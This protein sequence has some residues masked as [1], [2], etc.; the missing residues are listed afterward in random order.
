MSSVFSRLINLAGNIT[1]ILPVANGGTGLASGTSGG[2]LA[3]TAA[4]TLASSGALT[5]S[6]LVVGGGAGA[7]PA[8]LALG[9]A[10]QLLGMNAGA[11]ANEYKTLAVG[12]SGT[13]FAVANGAGTVTLNLP[14]ASASARGVITNGTQIIGGSKTFASGVVIGNNTTSDANY[15]TITSVTNSNYYR[16]N[17][18]VTFDTGAF[19][20]NQTVTIQYEK[21]GNLVMLFIPGVSTAAKGAAPGASISNSSASNFGSNLR[22][23]VQFYKVIT[24][25]NGG[26][27]FIGNMRVA[28]TGAI[29]FFANV[30]ESTAY[31]T[32]TNC[33]WNAFSVTYYV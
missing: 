6:A 25:V 18:D 11:S 9:S 32:T 33:G 22:P 26:N 14:D 23:A 4:G 24:G 7:A 27:N 31:T 5:A 28:T 10:N 20:A 16:G 1:G 19:N 13:D 29:T 2:V 21:T 15:G 8:V 12:T 3:Y 30:N 17:F